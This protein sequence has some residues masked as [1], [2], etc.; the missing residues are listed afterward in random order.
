MNIYIYIYL[1]ICSNIIIFL[2][3][4]NKN[5]EKILFLFTILILVIISGTRIVGVDYLS[6]IKIFEDVDSNLKVGE[7]ER[8]FLLIV[9]ILKYKFYL[10][11]EYIFFFFS[12]LNLILLY[13]FIVNNL[14]Q[15]YFIALLIWYTFYFFKLDMGQ[16]RFELAVVISLNL[17]LYFENKKYIKFLIGN[18][19]IFFIHRTS[20][21][22]SSIFSIKSKIFRKN[23]IFYVLIIIFIFGKLLIS[24]NLLLIIGNLIGSTKLKSMAYGNYSY[25]IGFSLYQI[26][27]ILT[28]IFLKLYK[29][30]NVKIILY[31]KIYI[32]G[33][34]LYF[35]FINLAIFSDRLPLYFQSVLVVLYPMIIDD[36][37]KR[38][39]RNS[40]L[41]FILIVTFYLF[42]RFLSS[43]ADYY[44]PYR[45]WLF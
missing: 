2:F 28:L 35:F 8:A 16:F 29:T 23:N 38:Y 11:N 4:K 12:F 6:Y 32:I 3:Y 44:L 39:K 19:I 24:R 36:T 17:L 34:Y 7:I 20:I 30:S 15:N 22:Y 26:Y 9:Y 1:F 13:R 41:L 5:I 40:I 33:V 18:I 43:D 42:I 14:K 37:K 31:K 21:I 10:K 45:S 25:Q 27:L